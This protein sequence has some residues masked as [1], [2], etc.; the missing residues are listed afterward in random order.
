MIIETRKQEFISSLLLYRNKMMSYIVYYI[1]YGIPLKKLAKKLKDT[2]LSFLASSYYTD[3]TLFSS[4]SR[5]A[6]KK[7]S[8]NKYGLVFPLLVFFLNESKRIYRAVD[9]QEGNRASNV[10][11][12]I[13]K[14]DI[15]GDT[16]KIIYGE[17]NQFEGEIK[18]DTIDEDLKRNRRGG[19]GDAVVEPIVFYLISKHGDCAEDHLEAQGK[20]YI[21]DRYKSFIHDKD[22]LAS[23]EAFVALHAIAS[24]Q[25]ILKA[26]TWM[27]TRPNCRHYY[28]G[29]PTWEALNKSIDSLLA[30][31]DMISATGRRGTRQT[32]RHNTDSSWYTRENIESIIKQ[33]EQRLEYLKSIDNGVKGGIDD[34][35]KDIVKTELLLKKWREYL[36]TKF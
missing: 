7:L 23:V 4:V 14:R 35:K 28:L 9:R 6:T 34:V 25:D 26:P 12:E 13:K 10:Y 22:R 33:Y 29:I 27:I 30:K 5:K 36:K 1:V 2:T 20:L 18:K 19:G 16:K 32:I 17:A 31:Y 24:F 3:V 21:D 11:R 15:N 8:K